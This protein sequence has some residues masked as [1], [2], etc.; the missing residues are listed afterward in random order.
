MAALQPQAGERL[1]EIGSGIGG[2]ARWFATTFKCHV[3]GIDLTP[4]FCRAAEQLNQVTRLAE[5]G[6]PVVRR[7]QRGAFTPL[8]W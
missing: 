1:L 2:P 5:H 4:A 8:P 3:T 7:W 6:R